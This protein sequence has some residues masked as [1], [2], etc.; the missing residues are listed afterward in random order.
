MQ[1]TWTKHRKITIIICLWNNYNI[2][3]SV[4]GFCSAKDAGKDIKHHK[5][6]KR[7]QVVKRW[8]Q[9]GW[10]VGWC[11]L[12]CLTALSI[13]L[14]RLATLNDNFTDFSQFLHKSVSLNL[15]LF[16]VLW[17]GSLYRNLLTQI[18][19]QWWRQESG[20]RVYNTNLD[21]QNDQST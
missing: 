7:A 4:S 12:Y 13:I 2:W 17:K 3:T 19:L 1:R 20:L 8:K 18:S 21:I 11:S 15:K 16:T 10:N 6:Q 14:T 9:T 5:G